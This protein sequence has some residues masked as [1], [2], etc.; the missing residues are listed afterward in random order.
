MKVLVIVQSFVI[1]YLGFWMYENYQNDSY[2]QSYVNASLQ[3]GGFT[4][5]ALSSIGIFSAIAMVLYMKLRRTHK[6]LENLILTEHSASGDQGS[7]SILDANVEQHL[8]EMIRKSTPSE[9]NTASS[10]IPIL[11]RENPQSSR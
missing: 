4:I 8:M 11:E 6:E 5:I 10:S 2:F 7:K 9:T 3:G 1:A